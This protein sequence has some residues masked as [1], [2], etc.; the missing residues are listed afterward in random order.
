MRFAQNAPI[1]FLI[2]KSESIWFFKLVF[3]WPILYLSAYVEN[4]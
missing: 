3:F 1:A 2:A 4:E